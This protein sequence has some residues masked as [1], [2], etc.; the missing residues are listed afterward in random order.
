MGQDR[1]KG[2]R[3]AAEGKHRGRGET[4]G[5]DRLGKRG[6]KQKRRSQEKERVSR[7]LADDLLLFVCTCSVWKEE[8]QSVSELIADDS[9]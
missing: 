3:D 6:E 9:I 5:Q 7:R 8:L 2:G 1:G 4:C